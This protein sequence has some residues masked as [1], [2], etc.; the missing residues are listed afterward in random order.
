MH[1]AQSQ[2]MNVSIR[3][4]DRLA[5][6]LAGAADAQRA[7]L[8]TYERGTRPVTEPVLEEN[9][10]AGLLFGRT[11]GEQRTRFA[12]KLRG[13]AAD[14]DATRQYALRTAGYPA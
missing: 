8:E 7:A 13:V 11:V 12:K 1:P 2:G 3:Y 5:R 14:P 9:H 10:R 6:E 4:V